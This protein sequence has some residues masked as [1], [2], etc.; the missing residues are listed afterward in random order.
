MAGLKKD[1]PMALGGIAAL[2]LCCA[3]FAFVAQWQALATVRARR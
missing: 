2:F 3:G 1:N